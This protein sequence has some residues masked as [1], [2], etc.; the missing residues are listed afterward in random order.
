VPTVQPSA[1]PVGLSSS[2]RPA[3]FSAAWLRTGL[4][5]SWL[6]AS[7]P[8]PA[9]LDQGS[10]Q[11]LASITDQPAD[12]R[13][14]E[15]TE[16]ADSFF[17]TFEPG[18]HRAVIAKPWLARALASVVRAP[19]GP[20]GRTEDAKRLWAAADFPAGPRQFSWDQYR[21][22]NEHRAACID[23]LLADG[24]A[25]LTGIPAEPG[26][27]LEVAGS[28]GFVRETNYGRLSD[29]QAKV[30]S[31][32]LAYTAMAI[33]PDTDN[34]Y[35]DPVPTV[36]LLHCLASAAEGGDSGLWTGSPRPACCGRKTRPR[37]A[38]WPQPR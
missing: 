19:G 34:P 9:C 15:V 38:S 30:D 8:C 10:G 26:M 23:S 21:A 4:S 24:F 27:V 31:A 14:G 17:V 2:W 1:L 29:V 36:Q 11:R 18:G 5:A 25:L 33:A 22:D 16:D 3:G 37:S 6:R 28:L 13:L 35:R 7:C 20:A 12:V 32:N